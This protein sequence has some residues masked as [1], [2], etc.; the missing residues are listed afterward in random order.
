MIFC[1]FRLQTVKSTLPTWW[2]YLPSRQPES[3]AAF[4]FSALCR[5]QPV[6]LS[7]RARVSAGD[8]QGVVLFSSSSPLLVFVLPAA[9]L[10]CFLSRQSVSRRQQLSRHF[11]RQTVG[12][13]KH[14]AKRRRRMNPLL[15]TDRCVHLKKRT[16]LSNVCSWSAFT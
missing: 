15:R 7:S 12:V 4:Y 5:H 11:L 2:T 16:N 3:D 8:P 9:L 1:L 10:L 6:R 14:A 13:L